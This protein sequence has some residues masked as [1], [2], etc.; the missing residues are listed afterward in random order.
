MKSGSLQPGIWTR[1]K[2][3]NIMKKQLKPIPD[4]K[5]E[6]EERAFWSTHSSTD[7]VD[8]SKAYRPTEP[9]HNLKPS[10]DL[11]EFQLPL[12]KL[13]S[14]NSLAKKHHVPRSSLVRQYV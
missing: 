12:D 6:D 13:E 14:L 4:F 5:N 3:R 8:W 1:K 10:E 9:L 2:N 7:Y 11:V